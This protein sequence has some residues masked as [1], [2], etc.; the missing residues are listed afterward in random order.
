MTIFLDKPGTLRHD[1]PMEAEMKDVTRLPAAETIERCR[2]I[3]ERCLRI[4]SDISRR[5]HAKT[6]DRKSVV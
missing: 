3:T 6:L 4:A 2:K 1:V 5:Q